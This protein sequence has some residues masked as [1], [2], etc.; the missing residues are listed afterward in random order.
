MSAL[1]LCGTKHV[2]FALRAMASHWSVCAQ[3]WQELVSQTTVLETDWMRVRA[4]AAAHEEAA[5]RKR[6]RAVDMG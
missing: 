3:V 1:C 4:K 2:A 5:A 6:P